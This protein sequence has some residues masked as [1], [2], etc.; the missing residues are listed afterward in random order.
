MRVRDLARNRFLSHT[1]VDIFYHGGSTRAHAGL[2]IHPKPCDPIHISLSELSRAPPPLLMPF[3]SFSPLPP[4]RSRPQAPRWTSGPTW[5]W[6][7]PTTGPCSSLRSWASVS[8]PQSTSSCMFAVLSSPP[9]FL[10]PT[11]SHR[12]HSISP[13]HARTSLAHKDKHYLNTYPATVTPTHT[14]TNTHPGARTHTHTHIN[15]HAHTHTHK[16]SHTHTHAHTHTRAHTTMTTTH[17]HTHNHAHA[18]I[19]TRRPPRR[20]APL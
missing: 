20:E 3:I 8:S 4:L 15:A 9:H 17:T 19:K 2:T 10:L 12:T 18:A 1:S 13:P 7:R 5:A 6:F 11:R 14:H 16:R